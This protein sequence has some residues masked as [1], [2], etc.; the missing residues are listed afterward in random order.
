MINVYVDKAAWVKVRTK[1]KSLERIAAIELIIDELMLAA[2]ESALKGDLKEFNID[3]GQTKEKV[4]F[5]NVAGITASIN[6][7]MK[8]QDLLMSR[9]NGQVIRLVDSN[10]LPNNRYSAL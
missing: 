4:I 7:L 9:V 1:E 2:A 3:D 10:A 6:S 8:L 5:E